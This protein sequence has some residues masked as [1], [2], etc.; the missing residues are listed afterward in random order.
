[1]GDNFDEARRKKAVELKAVEVLV[2]HFNHVDS[3][4]IAYASA[5]LIKYNHNKIVQCCIK[6]S[7]NQGK[8]ILTIWEVI[9]RFVMFSKLKDMLVTFLVE[10][11]GK[12]DFITA[13]GVP[14]LVPMLN[15]S[16]TKLTPMVMVVSYYF[17]Y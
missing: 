15:L 7:K 2:P 12:K 14:V 4:V 8:V 9:L 1:M 16:D 17:N 10:V 3:N 11:Q 13:N 6:I 5:A